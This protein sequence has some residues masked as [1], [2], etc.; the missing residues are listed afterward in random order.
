[1]SNEEF[2]FERALLDEFF[3]RGEYLKRNFEENAD[4]ETITWLKENCFNQPELEKY[5]LSDKIVI[6]REC[7]FKMDKKYRGEKYI[8]N[9]DLPFD[10]DKKIEWV[11]RLHEISLQYE[12]YAPELLFPY[13]FKDVLKKIN[14]EVDL[15]ETILFN[16]EQT[17][18]YTYRNFGYTIST[19]GNMRPSNLIIEINFSEEHE[20]QQYLIQKISSEI[21][22]FKHSNNIKITP[23]ENDLLRIVS[24]QDKSKNFRSNSLYNRA[25]G[26]YAWDLR[27]EHNISLEDER[28]K[29][30]Q[31]RLYKYKG[32][33]CNL[34]DCECCNSLDNCRR[35]FEDNFKIAAASIAEK[36]ILPTS[37][38]PKKVEIKRSEW[39]IQRVPVDTLE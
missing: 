38:K 31:E 39:L 1:M 11:T 12:V 33:M 8:E 15:P 26:I 3:I 25:I 21:A 22:M 9:I 29:L 32:N 14:N 35:A 30:V 19:K 13:D 2:L 6:V 37:H 16:Q 28:K 7:I 18:E 17:Y 4:I 20:M 27:K 10:T 5:I 34:S 24:A 36:K 23:D